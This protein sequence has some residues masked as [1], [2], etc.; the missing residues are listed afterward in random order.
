MQY[1]MGFMSKYQKFMF[2]KDWKAIERKWNQEN[3]GN[4]DT[5]Y[6]EVLLMYNIILVLGIVEHYT[7]E[8]KK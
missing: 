8:I 4:L 2:W 7:C 6:H 3:K 1:K 5:L